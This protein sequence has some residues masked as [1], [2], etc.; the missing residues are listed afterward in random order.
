MKVTVS[1]EVNSTEEA[2]TILNKVSGTSAGIPAAALGV[3]VATPH[4]APVAPV[5]VPSLPVDAFAGQVSQDPGIHGA[6]TQQA[7]VDATGETDVS[8]LPWDERIHSSNKK[9]TAK[10]VWTRRKGVSDLQ[11]ETVSAELRAKINAQSQIPQI[12]ANV[13]VI[14][15]PPIPQAAPVA[16]AGIPP[17]PQNPQIA[18]V[19]PVAA[20]VAPAHV[21]APVPPAAPAAVAGQLAP[22][23]P[24]LM[25]KVQALFQSDMA[26]TQVYLPALVARVS[27]HTGVPFGQ[28]NDIKEMP[29]VVAIV[30]ATIAADGK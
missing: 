19:A 1:F 10:N 26:G 17:V 28:L 27:G 25:A 13:P 11:F 2:Q 7:T 16:P 22:N 18:P 9:K 3:T 24:E 21:P 23:F 6:P 15:T 30:L 12:P 8:G 5:V 14:P 20:P 29:D 4:A